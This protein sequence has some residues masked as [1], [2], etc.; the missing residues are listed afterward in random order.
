MTP[1][2]RWTPSPQ[3]CHT[4]S[5]DWH[6][7][8]DQSTDCADEDPMTPILRWTPSL[9]RCHTSSASSAD[10]HR[11]RDQSTDCA[12]DG[13]MTPMLR[14][15]TSHQRH[16][17]S[18]AFI[19]GSASPAGSTSTSSTGMIRRRMMIRMGCARHRI[20]TS[21]RIARASGRCLVKGWAR[22]SAQSVAAWEE[23]RR[24]RSY[25][26]RL[27][28]ARRSAQRVVAQQVRQRALWSAQQLAG[29]SELW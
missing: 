26:H 29:H 7:G 17:T 12:D 3:R 2:L 11:R 22:S 10:W 9:Q 28:L 21:V 27:D 19:C 23:A 6:R 4:S 14:C 25:A 24:E 15:T 5:A 8:R 1:I 20:L 18:S 16:H 13:P